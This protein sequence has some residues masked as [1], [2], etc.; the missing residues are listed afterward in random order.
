MAESLGKVSAAEAR[1]KKAAIWTGLAELR[2]GPFGEG[3]RKAKE[4]V[5]ARAV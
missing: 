3:R 2:G 5:Q 4:Q 1:E